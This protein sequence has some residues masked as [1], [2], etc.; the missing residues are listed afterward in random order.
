MTLPPPPLKKSA[1][2]ALAPARPAPPP[3]LAPAYTRTPAI[4]KESLVEAANNAG[5]NL[6]WQAYSI[7]EPQPW[8]LGYMLWMTD[9]RKECGA[10][11]N[12]VDYVVAYINRT[13]TRTV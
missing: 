6:Y 10:N 7:V 9:R 8:P 1:P 11:R 2:I 5:V 12:L 13:P 3:S 4:T